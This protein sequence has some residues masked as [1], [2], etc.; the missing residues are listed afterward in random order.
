[1]SCGASDPAAGCD[2][3]GDGFAAA[4]CGGPDCDDEDAAVRPGAPEAAGNGRD[5][6]CDGAT[7]E[8]DDDDASAASVSASGLC[9]SP[10]TATNGVH[11][12]TACTGPLS[13]SGGVASNGTW[14]L[15]A[16][17]PAVVAGD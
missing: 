1:M 6:D 14:T 2:V 15:V 8:A 3:D 4:A 12:V 16:G 10:G 11:R 17:A 9:A 5:D 7:D 13:A